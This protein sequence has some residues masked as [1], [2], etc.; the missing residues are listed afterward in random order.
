MHRARKHAVAI[1][2]CA[3][4]LA[5]S[6]RA[7]AFHAGDVFDKAPGAGG[8][9]GI[10]YT[11]IGSERGW[12]CA[13]CH[14]DAPGTIVMRVESDPPA[15]FQSLRYVP[16]QAYAIKATM[17]GEHEGLDSPRSNYNAIALAIVDANDAAA[18]SITGYAAEEFYASGDATIASKGQKV[19][20]TSWTFTWHAPDGDI[21]PVAMHLAAVDGN[22]ANSGA[23]GTLTD[24]WGDDVFVGAL[25][26]EGTSAPAASQ[27]GLG[28]GGIATGVL[29]MARRTK[30]RRDAR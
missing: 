2:A 5:S 23:N 21:G 16:G 25:R 13:A 17:V 26:L 9:G 19:G 28:L 6:G 1:A 11:G 20:E 30:K 4:A 29:W 10:F 8:G 27:Q 12:T 14:T 22:G 3:I 7:L 24:P 18:G 15:L